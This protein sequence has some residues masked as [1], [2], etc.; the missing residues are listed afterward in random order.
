[1]KHLSLALFI[2]TLAFSLSSCTKSTEEK[3]KELSAAKIKESLIVPDSYDLAS[4]EIDSAFTPYDSPEFYDLAIELAKDGI[5]I[6]QAASDKEHAQSSIALWGGPYQ[7]SFGRN[8]QNQAKADFRKA[9]K[10]ES[11]ATAHARSIAEK[12]KEIMSQKSE[13]IGMKAKVKYRAK[14][15]AGQVQMGTAKIL[16]DKD[17]TKVASIYDMDGDEYQAFIAIINEIEKKANE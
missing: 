4:I 16:F 13:F 6:S 9:Q 14:D 11:D 17:M 5:A 3:A 7:T 12:M 2:I 10:A 15:N 1:M 8:E